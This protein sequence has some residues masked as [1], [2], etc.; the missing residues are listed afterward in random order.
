MNKFCHKIPQEKAAEVQQI[1]LYG[2]TGQPPIRSVL[3]SEPAHEEERWAAYLPDSE[4]SGGGEEGG[5]RP[6][7]V[8]VGVVGAG[9]VPNPSV[10][11]CYVRLERVNRMLQCL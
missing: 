6:R 4:G 9:G 1:F 5:R 11:Y 10:N 8:V 2:R 7:V 3:N